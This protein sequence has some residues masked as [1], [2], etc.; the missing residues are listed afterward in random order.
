[1]KGITSA[2]IGVLVISLA[3][4]LPHAAPDA[5]TL[6]ILGLTVAAMVLWRVSPLPLMAGGSLAGLVARLSR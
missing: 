4:L 1:M 3:R 2:V 6:A 5:F